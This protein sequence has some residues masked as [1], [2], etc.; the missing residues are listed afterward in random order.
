MTDESQNPFDFDIDIKPG[1]V[2]GR[3]HT[4]PGVVTSPFDGTMAAR[5][6]ASTSRIFG[7]FG[8]NSNEAGA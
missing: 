2:R 5:S 1:D 6:P 7:L 3:S 8:Q 4:A